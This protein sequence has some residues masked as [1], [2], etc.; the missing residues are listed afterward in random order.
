MSKTTQLFVQY[1][2]WFLVCIIRTLPQVIVMYDDI[3]FINNSI[4]IYYHLMSLPHPCCIGI[5]PFALCCL[6]HIL[7]HLFVILNAHTYT[8]N[9]CVLILVSTFFHFLRRIMSKIQNVYVKIVFVNMQT[10]SKKILCIFVEI[11]QKIL[12]DF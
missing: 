7:Y 9:K 11:N 12:L 10:F 2:S 6:L 1:F 4:I 3:T 8:H 5:K